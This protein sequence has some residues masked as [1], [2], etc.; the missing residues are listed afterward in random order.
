[1]NNALTT[2]ST[3]LICI[4]CPIGCDLQVLHDTSEILS[5]QGNLCPRGVDYAEKELFDP[6]RT[7]TT[8]VRVRG[9]EMPLAS[10]RTT[11]PVPKHLIRKIV[12]LV[13]ELKLE[14]PVEFGQVIIQDV[15]GTGVD[16]VTTRGVRRKSERTLD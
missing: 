7:I 10:V 3:S 6:H 4:V 2:M 5:V 16:V 1:M 13:K 14:A 15:E 9:G 11:E 12:A 8:S